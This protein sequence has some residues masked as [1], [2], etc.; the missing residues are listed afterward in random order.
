MSQRKEKILQ[1]LGV[2]NFIYKKEYDK[3]KNPIYVE[4]KSPIN[5]NDEWREK[6]HEEF[7]NR[8]KEIKQGVVEGS[9]KLEDDEYVLVEN[10]YNIAGQ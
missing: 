10:M 3:N 2:L 6:V 1:S 4:G 9:D 7:S 5:H 8:L